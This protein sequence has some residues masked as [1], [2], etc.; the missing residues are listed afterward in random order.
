MSVM[1]DLKVSEVNT[2]RSSVSAWAGLSAAS[3][4]RSTSSAALRALLLAEGV[5]WLELQDLL[6]QEGVLG[7]CH[8]PVVFIALP[9]LLRVSEV[10][11]CLRRDIGQ[12]VQ[13][14]CQML[15]WTCLSEPTA[16]SA[17]PCSDTGQSLLLWNSAA[18]CDCWLP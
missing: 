11:S 9:L 12:R 13:N 1:S 8:V 16:N 7:A 4:T 5:C 6:L 10:K 17:P 3:A 2:P 14:S 15:Y 18:R